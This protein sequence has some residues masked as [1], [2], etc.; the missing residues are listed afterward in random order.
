MNEDPSR[1]RSFLTEEGG[2]SFALITGVVLSRPPVACRSCLGPRFNSPSSF[3]LS[4]EDVSRHPPCNLVKDF[5]PLLR[6]SGTDRLL[7][8]KVLRVTV[9]SHSPS[10]EATAFKVRSQHALDGHVPLIGAGPPTL[11]DG[12]RRTCLSRVVVT[13]V[14]FL[15]S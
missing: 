9:P 1:P 13:R 6:S 5:H 2:A 10:V 11:G 8:S 15:L 14:N 4:T 12:R 3:A 7:L